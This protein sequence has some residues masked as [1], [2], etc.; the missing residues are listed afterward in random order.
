VL[1]EQ[2]SSRPLVSMIKTL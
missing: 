1:A 2:D